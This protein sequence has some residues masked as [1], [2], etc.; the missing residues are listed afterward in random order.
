MNGPTSRPPTNWTF[1]LGTSGGALLLGFLFLKGFLLPWQKNAKDLSRL[2]DEV[3]ALENDFK[4]FMRDKKKL[5]SYKLLGLPRDLERSSSGYNEYLYDLL[6]HCG[7]IGIVIKPTGNEEKP[8]SQATS[9]GAKKPGHLTLAF[10]VDAQGDWVSLTKMLEQFQRT[11]FLH[12]L[13]NLSIGPSSKSAKA[14]LSFTMNIETLVVH[15]NERRPDNLWGFDPKIFAYDSVLALFGQPS[16]WAML[17]RGQALL[18]PEAPP[19][20]YSDLAWVN[21][22]VGGKPRDPSEK[23]IAK[24]EGKNPPKRSEF[25]LAFTNPSAQRAMLLSGSTEKNT[26]VNLQALDDFTVFDGIDQV[27]G[28]VVR[29]DLGEVFVEVGGKVYGIGFEKTLMDYLKSPLS[30]EEQKERGLV[31]EK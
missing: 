20:R 2:E 23:P 30:V 18:I 5:E 29:V 6:D 12:R 16:G 9:G 19:R 14:K 26:V 15:Q 3:I 8:K 1:I 21:P 22:F 27:K 11:A 4:V 13:R 25:R 28:R 31:K 10:Q 17:L 7:F 24:K